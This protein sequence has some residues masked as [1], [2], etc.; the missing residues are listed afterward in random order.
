[1][2]ARFLRWWLSE[3]GALLPPGLAARPERGQWL[4][5]ELG[6]D[7]GGRAVLTGSRERVLL[8]LAPAQ[9]AELASRLGE[10]LSGLDPRRV[11]CRVSLPRRQVL[12]RELEL[13]LAAEE[14]LRE[15]L[16]F[17][18]SRRTPFRAED[19]HF[20]YRIESR[21]AAAQQLRV[22]LEVVPREVLAPVLGALRAWDPE[23]DGI[24]AQSA[25]DP[26]A[27]RAL[28][29]FRGA[30][31]R[32]R[33]HARLNAVLGMMVVLLAAALVWT[34]FAQQREHR[35]RRAGALAAAR[36]E[37]AQVAALREALAAE[38]EARGLVVF[39][40]SGA[41]QRA[42]PDWGGYAASKFALRALADALRDEEAAAGVRVSS[43]YPGRTATPMQREVRRQE[44]GPYDAEAY[45][46]PDAV[47]DLIDVAP[48]ATVPDVSVRP[49]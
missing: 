19:V 18:M 11:R 21:D 14:N 41:G 30:A 24:P 31:F 47:A 26:G 35:P 48:S 34:P 25:S 10:V 5:V 43:V 32:E 7:E 15:V 45:L 27:D 46:R 20:D 23:P 3:L 16:A 49:G 2:I 33:P 8:E 17:E 44:G 40:N 38:R 9:R 12:A 42:K 6:E 39:V 22:H 37:A 29:A 13:P 1:V 4:T 36:A 28:F